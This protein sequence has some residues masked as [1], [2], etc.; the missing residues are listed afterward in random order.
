MEEDNFLERFLY[1][2]LPIVAQRRHFDNQTKERLQSDKK[3]KK[4][5]D[6]I[7]KVKNV[8]F[9]LKLVRVVFLSWVIDL[10]KDSIDFSKYQEIDWVEIVTYNSQCMSIIQRHPDNAM[11]L[12]ER[13][14]KVPNKRKIYREFNHDLFQAIYDQVNKLYLTF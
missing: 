5:I 1:K 12:L 4:F 6:H 8:S 3:F 7:F 13:F 11:D 9:N 2:S 10:T 14:S